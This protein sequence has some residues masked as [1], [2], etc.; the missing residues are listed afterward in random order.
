MAQN[1]RFIHTGELMKFL[2]SVFFMLSSYSSL[3]QECALSKSESQQKLICSNVTITSTKTNSL[4]TYYSFDI[5]NSI[6]LNIELAQDPQHL[7]SF[8]FSNKGTYKNS[9]SFE[10]KKEVL[11][12]LMEIQLDQAFSDF[13]I[14]TKFFSNLPVDED[15]NHLTLASQTTTAARESVS[16]QYQMICNH[17]G[18]KK[19]GFYNID[20]ESSTFSEIV[21][22]GD[23]ASKCYGRCGFGCNDKNPIYTQE[24]LNHDICHR[25]TGENLGVCSDE[26]WQASKGFVFAPNCQF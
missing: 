19:E 15:L 24:C 21:R 25:T 7:Q 9:L 16:R 8:S 11:K 13:Y 6:T 17:V 4:S 20:G 10:N 12:V 22:V 18:R 2:I 3:A 23:L 5:V 26:F 1:F 14:P